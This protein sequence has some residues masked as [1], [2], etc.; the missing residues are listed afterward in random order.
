LILMGSNGSS[1]YHPNLHLLAVTC[2]G[3]HSLGVGD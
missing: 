1:Q 2:S 3:E